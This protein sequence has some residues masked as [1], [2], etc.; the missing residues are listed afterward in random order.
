MTATSRS[1]GLLAQRLGERRSDLAG[2]EV[3]V[4]DV[5]QSRAACSAF[6]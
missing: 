2:P 6:P 1:P 4:L 3:L 5:D